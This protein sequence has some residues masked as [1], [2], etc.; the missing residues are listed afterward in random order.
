M[1]QPDTAISKTRA[2]H[3]SQITQAKNK[4]PGLGFFFQ[5]TLQQE[6]CE[7]T[8]AAVW[9]CIDLGILLDC[10]Q[11]TFF[12]EQFFA[13]GRVLQEDSC[14]SGREMFTLVTDQFKGGDVL[15]LN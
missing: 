10:I 6:P 1:P 9:A 7:E 11:N 8:P 2:K 14:L 15:K 13:V 3:C 12:A 4:V 5:L